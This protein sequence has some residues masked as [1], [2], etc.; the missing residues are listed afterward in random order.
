MW[1]RRRP[2]RHPAVSRRARALCILGVT[3]AIVCPGAEQTGAGVEP[4]SRDVTQY[5]ILA[6]KNL[7]WKNFSFTV[8]GNVGVNDPGGTL[9]YGNQSFFPDGSQ[10]AA[11][12]VTRIGAHSSL[13]DLFGNTVNPLSL[14][15]STLRNEG[16]LA[17]TPPII[18][19][20]PTLPPCVP[21]GTAV[22]VPT[23]GAQTLTAGS[24]GAVHVKNGATLT[25]GGGTY[26]LASVKAGRH[27]KLLFEAPAVVSVAGEMKAGV[28]DV[29]GPVPGSGLG[30]LDIKFDIAGAQ[31]TLSHH[32]NVS[33]GFFAPNALLRF[34]RGGFF[35]GQ[36]VAA[37]AVSDFGDAFT[38][39]APGSST[40]TTTPATT[41]TTSTTLGATTTTTGASTTSTTL[42]ST[43]STT[44]GATTTTTPTTST[45]TTT[46]PVLC[47]L[48]PGAYGAPGGIVNG[49]SGLITLNPGVLPV[50]VGG[51]T[52][53]TVSD[54]ASLI[55]FMPTG[56]SPNALC[57]NAQ[58]A[59]CPGSLVI[60]GG[61]PIPDPS[62]SGSFGYGGGVLTGQTLALTL[63]VR[64]SAVGATTPGLA[65]L[66]LLVGPFCTC[67]MS[68]QAGPF[69]VPPIIS[70]IGVLTVSDL[71]ALAN[72]ALQGTP[73]TVFDPTLHYSDISA[74]LD[75]INTGFDQCRQL[76]SCG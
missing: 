22:T 10:L 20:L 18:T 54:Q 67:A 26:C 12:I 1:H 45:T 48:T 76:C 64:L 13:W 19:T 66:D 56:D 28:G 33:G 69:M 24:Y 31:V 37:T 16:P 47:S 51:T 61:G 68:G 3:A 59:P 55:A 9:G 71:L 23:N 4:L 49:P 32:S 27:V 57:G 50:S 35:H 62:G 15:Q 43:T 34:G 60:T 38:L 29:I 7:K 70:S 36:Y 58:P 8:A 21:S 30:A 46:A 75:A 63:S 17:F 39:G 5:V 41:S 40:T 74:A 44:V 53:V 72:Q 2:T 25:L 11:D 14:A 42:G 6:R 65:N 73:L 52:S